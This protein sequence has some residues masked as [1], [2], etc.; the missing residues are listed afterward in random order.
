MWNPSYESYAGPPAGTPTPRLGPLGNAPAASGLG[1][2]AAPAYVPYH[3]SAPRYEPRPFPTP[4]IE[5]RPERPE[6]PR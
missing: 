1:S 2:I 5:P 6:P 4:E 3:Q